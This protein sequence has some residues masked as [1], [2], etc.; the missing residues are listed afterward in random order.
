M[1]YWQ[2]SAHPKLLFHNQHATRMD[3]VQESTEKASRIIR[4]YRQ[5]YQ[6]CLDKSV[7]LVKERWAAEGALLFAFL[8]RVVLARGWYVECYA[9]AIFML[10]MLLGFLSPKFDPGLE[11]D[12]RSDDQEA[13]LGEGSSKD[14]EF[15]PFV[16]RLPEYQFWFY[17]FNGTL[18]ALLTTMFRTLDIPVF[19]PILVI[20]FIVLFALTMRRQIQHMIKYRYIPFDI[21]K[22]KFSAKH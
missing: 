17:S 6:V 22:K 2:I 8:L 4:K 14:D 18:L 20:Y 1:A 13:G 7:P 12:L 21:G 10:N 11:D 9:L 5:K 3:K 15:R 16:R 19:W